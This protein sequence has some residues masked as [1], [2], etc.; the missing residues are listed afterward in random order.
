MGPAN[1]TAPIV[2][3][4]GCFLRVLPHEPLT[5][6]T[7]GQEQLRRRLGCAGRALSGGVSQVRS[8]HNRQLRA[9]ASMVL[10]RLPA[11][12]RSPG[13]PA[14]VTI[15]EPAIWGSESSDRFPHYVPPG[16]SQT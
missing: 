9:V 4:D 7:R 1:W 5:G 13:H 16:R 6:H 15:T 11:Q 12:H 8:T 14:S 10:H 2:K 3:I